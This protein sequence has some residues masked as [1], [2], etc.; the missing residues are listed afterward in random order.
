MISTAIRHNIG[1]MQTKLSTEPSAI[2]CDMRV[3]MLTEAKSEQ[4]AMSL[5]G[6]LVY[7]GLTNFG[8]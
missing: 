5:I 8:L 1:R 6:F 3:P 7:I 4:I 2:N